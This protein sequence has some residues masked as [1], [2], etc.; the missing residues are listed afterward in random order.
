MGTTQ[1]DHTRVRWTY[2]EFA[3]LPESG[4][5]RYEVIGDE[6]VVTPAPGRRHQQVLGRLHLRLGAFVE[7][8]DLGEVYVGPFDVLLAEGDYLEPDLLFVRKGRGHIVSDRGVEGP[9]DLVVEIVS[10]STAA[11]DRGLKLERYRRH[12]V[13][14]YWIVDP[15][16]GTVELWKLGAGADEPDVLKSSDTL[17]WTA[18]DSE[19]PMLAIPLEELLVDG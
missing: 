4:S 19:G 2:S 15:D 14:E 16:R 8:R 5:T 6:L 13:A 7:E 18:P 1:S 17:R 9:P 3:R 11:R 10:P 12:G